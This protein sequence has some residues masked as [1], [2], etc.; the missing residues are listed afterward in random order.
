[1]RCQLRHLRFQ[2]LQQ[3][4]PEGIVC[5]RLHHHGTCHP[6]QK[7]KGLGEPAS[8]V[9]WGLVKA[10]WILIS[11]RIRVNAA[12]QPDRANIAYQNKAV[13]YNLLFATTAE[14]LSTI[15]ADPK[16]LGA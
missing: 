16:H 7:A 10:Q 1:L 8:Q 3:H 4:M 14:T 9:H 15:A 12:T 2:Q 13:V 11:I 5:K 6:E